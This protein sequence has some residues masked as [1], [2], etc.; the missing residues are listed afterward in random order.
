M[1]LQVLAINDAFPVTFATVMSDS[2]YCRAAFTTQTNVRILSSLVLSDFGTLSGDG[3]F[4]LQP[5]S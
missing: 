4:I 2:A 1:D 5:T 3:E